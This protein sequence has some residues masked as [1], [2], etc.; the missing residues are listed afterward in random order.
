M[1]LS[2]RMAHK[3]HFIWDDPKF[4]H[5]VMAISMVRVGPSYHLGGHEGADPEYLKRGDM[6]MAN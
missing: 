4:G 3:G 2:F 6:E 5:Y 1:T